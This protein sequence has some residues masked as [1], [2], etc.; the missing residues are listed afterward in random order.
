VDLTRINPER[1]HQ[2][3]GYAHVTIVDSGRLA[4]LAGQC[5]L[6]RDEQVVGHGDVL[7]Q[8]DQVAAN[9]AEA[10]AAAGATPQ[11]V[12]RSV[13][14]VVSDDPSV[15]SAVWDR[16]TASVIGP[17]FTTASTLL[18]VAALGYR[19]QLVEIDLTAALPD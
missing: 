6:D 7:A 3:A 14:Y 1:L 18:G 9:A 12:I 11:D 16:V 19:G 13:I 2:T 17:A 4:V 15:L 5:P 8:V 10:L